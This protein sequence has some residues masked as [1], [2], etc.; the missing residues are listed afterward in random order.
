LCFLS[1]TLNKIIPTKFES[2]V[3]VT[4]KAGSKHE[5]LFNKVTESGFVT[6]LYFT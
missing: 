2:F 5:L 3:I 6:P 4:P 1:L